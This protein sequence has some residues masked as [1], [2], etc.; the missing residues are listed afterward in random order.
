MTADDELLDRELMLSR[1][2]RLIAEL[3]RGRVSR[4]LFH[5]WEIELLIDIEK[6]QIDLKRRLATL[7]RYERAVTRQLESGPG[8]PMKL[9]EFLQRKR[10]RRPSSE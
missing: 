2:R 5:Q 10:T 8:P 3:L 7:R 4:T 1:F 6:C 9:S